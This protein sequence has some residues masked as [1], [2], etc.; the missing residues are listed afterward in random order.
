MTEF[1]LYEHKVQYYETD[2]MKIVHHS[3]YIRWFE[4][5]RVYVLEKVGLGFDEME[6]MGII[7]P[8]LSASANYKSMV[9]FSDTVQIR[10][11]ATQYNGIKLYISYEIIDKETKEVRCTGETSHCFLDEKG[12]LISLK[13]KFPKVHEVF[14]KLME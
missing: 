12:N 7:C 4:E 13:R 11:K 8:V 10:L 6:K 2:Q 3:N 9:H 14:V 5:A 1:K